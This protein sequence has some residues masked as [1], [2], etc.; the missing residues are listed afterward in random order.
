MLARYEKHLRARRNSRGTIDLRMSA[1]RRFRAT[2][3][4]LREATRAD[5]EQYFE[6]HDHWSANYHNKTL[7]SLQL[8]YRWARRNGHVPPNP[9]KHLE[10]V[11]VPAA[12]PKPAPDSVVLDAFEQG[13]L[14]ERA[15]LCL[16]A[17]EGLRRT[18][19]ASAHPRNRDGGTL[20][21]IGKGAKER[22]VPLDSLTRS[23]LEDIER[24]QGV[25]EYYF[26]GRFTGHVHPATV[27][28]WLK[29]NLGDDWST[30][31]LRHRAA[32][33]AL[34]KTLDLRGVQ[35][36]LGHARLD[37]TQGY[38]AVS[39]ERLRALVNETSLSQLL[40]TRA[41]MRVA[42]RLEVISTPVGQGSRHGDA[43]IYAALQLLMDFVAE[44]QSAGVR[45]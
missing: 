26:P 4:Q 20:L 25:D 39:V 28:S 38:T 6:S 17:T 7:E 2:E 23:L 44:H 43:E 11:P 18:E 37:T 9:F 5:A 1:I 22:V 12:V 40:S 35:E 10:K 36:L 21:V 34:E 31:N 24:L 33:V 29:R 27:Y 16:G 8:F 19:I 30:H 41:L 15:M 42:D 3:D 14:A 45:R 13:T 32:T